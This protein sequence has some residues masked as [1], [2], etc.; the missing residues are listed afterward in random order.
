[1]WETEVKRIEVQLL[2]MKS[3]LRA[4]RRTALARKKRQSLKIYPWHK[5]AKLANHLASCCCSGCGN[6]RKW[7]AVKTIR[8]IRAEMC[9]N[10]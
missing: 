4:E 5:D 3:M 10:D 6:P 9:M 1:M 8:E 2:M 7:F